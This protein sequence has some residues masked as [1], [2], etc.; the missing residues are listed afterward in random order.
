[1][2]LI[3]SSPVTVLSVI[4]D[5]QTSTLKGKYPLSFEVWIFNNGQQVHNDDGR[6]VVVMTST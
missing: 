6:C 4:D 5:R 3:L 2:L 1:M